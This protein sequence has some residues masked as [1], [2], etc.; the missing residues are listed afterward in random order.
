[1]IALDTAVGY[2]YLIKTDVYMFFLRMWALNDSNITNT[3]GTNGYCAPEQYALSSQVRPEHILTY[4]IGAVGIPS[5][6]LIPLIRTLLLALP[7]KMTVIT[8]R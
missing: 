4:K 2:M 6:N 8:I 7:S 3:Y 1:M 5:D